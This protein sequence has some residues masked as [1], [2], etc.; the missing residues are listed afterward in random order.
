[1]AAIR[2]C[3]CTSGLPYRECCAPYHRGDEPPDCET[4]MRTRFSAF[5]LHDDDYLWRTLH[6]DHADRSRPRD[7]YRRAIR[8]SVVRYMGLAILDHGPPDEAGIGQVLFLARVFERG[9]ELSFVELSDFQ[10]DGVGFR[11]LR[12][13]T[14]P[15]SSIAGD[16]ERLT[17]ESFKAL[18]KRS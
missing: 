10:H 17:I 11:Y 6:P 9:K 12:G 4:L 5:A 7:L 13:V 15:R 8:G 14:V 2:H 16:P 1:M 3:P 18:M